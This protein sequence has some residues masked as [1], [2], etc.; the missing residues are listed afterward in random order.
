MASAAAFVDTLFSLKRK[1]ASEAAPQAQPTA[2]AIQARRTLT[3]IERA[4]ILLL[5]LGE[6]HGAGVWKLLDDDEIRSLSISM[7]SLGTIESESVERLLVDF[8]GQLSATGVIVKFSAA[9]GLDDGAI[10]VFELIVPVGQPPALFRIDE[11]EG[12]CVDATRGEGSGKADHE[13]AG[14]VRAGAV[15]KDQDRA[16][17]TAGCGPIRKC[18]DVFGRRYV[19]LDL[20][21]F[22]CIDVRHME[23]LNRS[24]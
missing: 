6:K 24:L 20:L 3:G 17:P 14:L 5:A 9:H 7:S 4:S 19:E 1:P 12:Y 11:V 13:A 2:A 10:A 23:A 22:R 21:G 18:G 8:V 16:C 15:R